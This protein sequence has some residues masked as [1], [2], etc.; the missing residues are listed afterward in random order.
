MEKIKLG[1]GKALDLIVCGIIADQQTVTIKFLP[2]ED[3]L[4]A[5]NSILMNT[6]ETEK[7]ILLSESGDQLA[8]YNGYT[9]LQS[10]GQELNAVIGYVQ[11]EIQTPIMGKLV[12]AT[13]QKP[14]RTEM[15]L[16]A[17]ETQLTDMQLALC[18]VYE[19][20]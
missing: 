16:E 6:S 9:Q 5:L 14:D 12:T 7:M 19:M 15:R 20:L 10:L 4:D 17:A 3:S 8:I 1:S 2:G 13:L 11:D 18:E